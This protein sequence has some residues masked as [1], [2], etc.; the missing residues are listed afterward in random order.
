M[1]ILETQFIQGVVGETEIMYD[2][3]PHVA[4][5]GRS[6]VGKSSTLNAITGKRRLVK[7]G[8]TPGKTKEI[9]FFEARVVD[10]EKEG[11]LYLVDLPGYG[12]AKLSKSKRK[13]L[14][15]LINW[16]LT[17]PQAD[18]ALVCL[19]IDAKVGLTDLDREMIELLQASQKHFIVA[20]NKV[21]KLNQKTR[22]KLSEEL[23]RDLGD[24]SYVFYSATSRKHVDLL[25]DTV[26]RGVFK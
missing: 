5:I 6:N 4:F 17:H 22:H 26:L 9:N 18:T 8:Q 13:E 10:G 14:S 1:K 20:V 16:Y 2:G 25:I 12:Y 3:T 11:L 24:V 7:V 19:I 15:G 23:K 21:D